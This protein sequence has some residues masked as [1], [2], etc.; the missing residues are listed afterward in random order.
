M[1]IPFIV[2]AED[3]TTQVAWPASRRS[4][5]TLTED[6][7][8][9][10]ANRVHRSDE[11]PKNTSPVYP[12]K[13]RLSTWNLITLS[14]SMAGAQIAWTVELGYAR[15]CI[16]NPNTYLSVSSY[17]TPFLLTLGVSEQLTSLV[18]LAG[19]ISGLIA[20]PLIGMYDCFLRTMTMS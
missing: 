9:D 17:G 15:S 8:N 13:Q 10:G 11:H 12:G 18:W 20:Q 6:V 5:D 1:T 7:G 19:P 14:I 4:P 3:P 2:D 16:T